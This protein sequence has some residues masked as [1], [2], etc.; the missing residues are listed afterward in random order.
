MKTYL[1]SIT[2]DCP[3]V[4]ENYLST[5]YKIKQSA[6]PIM[7]TFIPQ[8]P[9]VRFKTLPV[10]TPYPGNLSRFKYFPSGFKNKDMIV[11]TDASDVQFQC[12][13]PKLDTN[14][15]YVGAEYDFWGKENWWKQHLDRFEF[16]VLDKE[17]IFCMGTWAMSYKNVKELLQ[18]IK[19]NKERF[20]NWEQSDQILFN[21]WL[22]TKDYQIHPSLMV[23]LYNAYQTN[24]VF[25]TDLG[26]VNKEKK[27]YSIVHANGNTKD[28]LVYKKV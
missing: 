6:K 3:G 7:V 19:D 27:L 13:I 28:L 21:W 4:K 10:G 18:F 24:H 22:Q 23:N 2:S 9:Q 12:P 16:N 1:I 17:P 14:M 15:V 5:I 26:F 20:N 25:K 8:P 11:F